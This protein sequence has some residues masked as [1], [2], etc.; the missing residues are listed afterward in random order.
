LLQPAGRSA[1]HDRWQP[2]VGIKLMYKSDR[3]EIIWTDG[4]IVTI[5]KTSSAEIGWAVDLAAHTGLRLG[6]LLRLPW[7][8]VGSDAIVIATGKS[9]HRR[10]AIV[11]LYDALKAVLASIPRRSPIILTNTRSR[12]WSRDGFSSVFSKAKI[13][14]GMH[15]VD[16]HFHDLRGTAATR[17]YVAGLSERVVAE[18]MGWSEDH[19]GKIIRKYVDRAAATRA[20]IRQLNARGDGNGK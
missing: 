20:V 14:A 5:K 18:I 4:D 3:S 15:D 8:C 13:A 16:L 10:E 17:F 12:P 19:V 11:P 7:S 2:C 9:G 1:R 6:D